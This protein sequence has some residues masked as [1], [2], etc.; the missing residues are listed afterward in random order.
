MSTYS[1]ACQ[2]GWNVPVKGIILD[3]CQILVSGTRFERQ[4]IPRTSET[5]DEWLRDLS[6]WLRQME[7]AEGHWPQ[8]DKACGMYGGCQFRG[9]CARAPSARQQWLEADFRKRVW[10]PLVSRGDI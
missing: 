1:I 2:I 4:I 9:V 10:D 8:N 3:A 7:D 5:L 6:W